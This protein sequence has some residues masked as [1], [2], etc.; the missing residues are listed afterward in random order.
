MCRPCQDIV[1]GGT[2]GCA[3]AVGL[4]HAVEPLGATLR[5]AEWVPFA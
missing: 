3:F 1:P 5:L 4:R 2:G